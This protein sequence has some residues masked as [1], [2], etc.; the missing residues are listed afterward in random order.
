M[1]EPLGLIGVI[2]VAAQLIQLTTQL[3]LDW[4]DAPSEA[5][6]FILELQTLKT[7]LSETNTNILV[8][9]RF[10]DAFLGRRSAL[11]SEFDPLRDTTSLPDLVPPANASSRTWLT[12]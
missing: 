12:T 3:G 1:A 5:R 4:K 6:T 10:A 8:D 7:I 9:P 11:L 2:G